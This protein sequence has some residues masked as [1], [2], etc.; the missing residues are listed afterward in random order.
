MA[1]PPC[2][3]DAVYHV[4]KELSWLKLHFVIEEAINSM[5][6]GSNE[7]EGE[8]W[9]VFFGELM[10]WRKTIY[11]LKQKRCG[12]SISICIVWCSCR[13][14]KGLVSWQECALPVLTLQNALYYLVSQVPS[15]SSYSYPRH[16]NDAQ[17]YTKYTQLCS[18]QFPWNFHLSGYPII[19]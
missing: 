16:C 10:V 2:S 5:N 3:W 11:I 8:F 9:S 18:T 6:S 12:H 1:P 7:I 15:R 19:C 14:V 13:C 4:H 17:R